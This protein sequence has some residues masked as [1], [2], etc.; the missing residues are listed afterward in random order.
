[1]QLCVPHENELLGT[2]L[3]EAS[4]MDDGAQVVTGQGGVE[5]QLHSP[6]MIPVRVPTKDSPSLLPADLSHDPLQGTGG[7]ETWFPL[8][9]TWPNFILFDALKS[10][11]YCC[12]LVATA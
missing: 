7:L 3:L 11:Q 1:M 4:L 2:L 5:K 9:V 8:R 10:Q 6:V 12:A